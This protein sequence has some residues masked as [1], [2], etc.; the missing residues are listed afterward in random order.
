MFSGYLGGHLF[1]GHLSWI[2]VAFIPYVFLFYLKSKE[3]PNYLFTSALFLSLIFL[4]GGVQ[5]F[6]ITSLFLVVHFIVQEIINSRSKPDKKRTS[7]LAII[8]ILILIFTTLFAGFK[9]LPVMEFYGNNTRTSIDGSSLSFNLAV[10]SL[11]S[12]SDMLDD[13]KEWILWGITKSFLPDRS[14]LHDQNW[15]VWEYLFYIGV[16]PLL[17]YLVSFFYLKNNLDLK[18]V[19]IIFFFIALGSFATFAPWSLLQKLPLFNAQRV[20][21]RYMIFFLFPLTILVGRTLENLKA[22]FKTKKIFKVILIF[23]LIFVPIDLYSGHDEMYSSMFLAPQMDPFS[24]ENVKKHDFQP[25]FDEEF[26]ITTSQIT[27]MDTPAIYPYFKQ[28]VGVTHCNNVIHTDIAAKSILDDPRGFVYTLLPSETKLEKFTPN[29]LKISVKDSLV[30]NTLIINYNYDRNWKEL[31]GKEV[32]NKDGLLSVEI[33][34]QN[35]EI[36]LKYSPRS[37]YYGLIITLFGILATFYIIKK[38]KLYKLLKPK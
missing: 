5:L 8:L 11:V 2:T 16:I 34:E 37:F 18:I 9:L 10:L 30:P 35:E 31:S 22:K 17:L 6:T 25:K 7:R 23:V 29:T 14:A 33:S 19:G 21:S 24:P 4:G 36:N 3:N 26:Y 38:K 28:G 32:K 27:I 15:P 1:P 12:K 20:P 13:S